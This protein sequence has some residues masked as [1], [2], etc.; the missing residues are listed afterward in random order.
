MA[1]SPQTSYPMFLIAE[2]VTS[3]FGEG[4]C[5]AGT[6]ACQLLEVEKGM[7]T[8]FVFGEAEDSYKIT[9]TKVHPVTADGS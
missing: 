4:K 3:V 8:T 6:E 1:L 7:P 9:V 2:E 5:L